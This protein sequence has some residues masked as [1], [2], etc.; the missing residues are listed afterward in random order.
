MA[1]DDITNAELGRQIAAMRHDIQEDLAEIRRRQDAYV[2]REVYAAD[3]R[4]TEARMLTMERS[5]AELG[6]T[7]KA[8]DE[9]RTADRRLVVGAVISA[10]LALVVQLVLSL[11]GPV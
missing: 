1:G 2:L 11:R 6:A 3:Q 4:L 7:I 5:I 10:V 8:A 9:R